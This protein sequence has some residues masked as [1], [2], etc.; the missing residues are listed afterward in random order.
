MTKEHVKPEVVSE[1]VAGQKL[2]ESWGHSTVKVTRDG[3]AAELNLPIRSKGVSEYE[4]ILKDKAPEP[5]KT[6]K[7]IKKDSEAG[8]AA[9]LKHDQMMITYDAADEKYIEALGEHNI[10]YFWRVVIFAIDM[11]FRDKNGD[12]VTDYEG[13]KKILQSNGVAGHHINKMFQDIKNLTN[14]TEE[15]ADFLSGN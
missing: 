13:K 7:M 15:E 14:L 10:E 1:L 9:G 8:M 2:F 11:P 4:E 3:K 6:Y 12:L 5:P